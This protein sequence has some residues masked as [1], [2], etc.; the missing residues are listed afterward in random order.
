MTTYRNSLALHSR[1]SYFAGFAIQRKFCAVLCLTLYCYNLN[2]QMLS[3]DHWNQK[4]VIM[5]KYSPLFYEINVG[6]NLTDK[7]YYADFLYFSV[8]YGKPSAQNEWSKYLTQNNGEI[9][10]QS[11]QPSPPS[12]PESPSRASF[13]ASSEP[14][15]PSEPTAPAAPTA[16]MSGLHAGQIALGWQHFFNHWIGFHVQ[17]GWGFVADLGSDEDKQDNNTPNSS[18][19]N[20]EQQDKKTFVYNGVPT[21][22]GIDFNLWQHLVLQVGAIYMW[23]ERPYL[24][25]GL[26]ATF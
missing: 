24:T 8:G 4:T 5:G 2:A 3:T 19:D 9:N 18:G 25:L 20:E 22:V 12:Q 7:K 1:F 11:S 26:G 14:I 21:Q 17:A 23:K 10:P 15:Q 13:Q 16:S 6:T